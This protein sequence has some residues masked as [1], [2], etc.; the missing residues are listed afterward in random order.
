MLLQG[1][2]VSKTAD[3]VWP[4]ILTIFVGKLNLLPY[5]K[6]S[7]MMIYVGLLLMFTRILTNS[8]LFSTRKLF[9]GFV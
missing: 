6:L 8:F 1:K 5:C 3:I 2:A 9:M 4:Q 7:S